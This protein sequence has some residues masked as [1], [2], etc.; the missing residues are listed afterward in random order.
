MAGCDV[1]GAGNPLEAAFLLAFANPAA[2]FLAHY[3]PFSE[4]GRVRETTCLWT[5]LRRARPPGSREDVATTQTA[6][7]DDAT[8]P[9]AVWLSEVVMCI[10]LVLLGEAIWCPNHP[11]LANV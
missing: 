10:F 3:H 11:F 4:Q 8:R 2:F 5:G 1:T 7:G 9:R 6:T